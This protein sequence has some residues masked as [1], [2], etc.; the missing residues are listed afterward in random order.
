M[1]AY[2]DSNYL[3]IYHALRTR[4]YQAKG[5]FLLVAMMLVTVFSSLAQAAN[6]PM[7]TPAND[8][9]QGNLIYLDRHALD[10]ANN[11][12]SSLRL[13]RPSTT[14][15][16]YAYTCTETGDIAGASTYTPENS[17]GAGNIIYLDRH[18]VNCENKGLQYL[19]LERPTGNTVQY[20][21]K[22]GSKSLTDVQ[23]YFTP[24]NAD[25]GG[26]TIYLDR[27]NVSCPNNKVLSYL[28]LERPT[29]NTIRYHYKCGTFDNGVINGFVDVFA[30][31]NWN[32][33]G[34]ATTNMTAA[35]LTASVNFGGGGVTAAITIPEKGHINFDWDM[36]LHSAGQYGDVI[37]YVIN[38]TAYDLSTA[39]SASGSV[40]SVAVETGDVFE[41][42]TWGT[43][44]SSSYNATFDNFSFVPENHMLAPQ[45]AFS[46]DN[47]GR[48]D[49]GF[50]GQTFVYHNT[51]YGSN[52]FMWDGVNKGDVPIGTNSVT[53]TQ[54][55]VFTFGAEVSHPYADLWYYEICVNMP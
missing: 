16:A 35:A 34:V 49:V 23:D 28:K 2:I 48:N 29:G 21:Y 1:K 38:G 50:S 27:H 24:E 7:S 10:C 12:I 36:T 46:G 40:A 14:Q 3:C 53:D 20:H 18:T 11:V 47:Q 42:L 4:L 51:S 26:N 17:D 52:R 31:A 25:G 15:I 30:P 55:N 54:G 8:D 37:R 22:C 43:T 13:F 44:Q 32:I 41:F 45:C 9:G 5:V 33:S 6:Y 19:H 39:G